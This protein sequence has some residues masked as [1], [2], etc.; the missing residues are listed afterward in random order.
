MK[1]GLVLAGGG[2]RGAYQIGAIKALRELDIDKYIKVVSGTS[3]GALNAM[4]FMNGNL[5][6]SIEVWRNINKE[7]ILPTGENNLNIRS[8]I[9]NFGANNIHFIKKY[10]PRIISG[11]NISRCGLIE[12]MNKID[13]SFVKNSEIICYAACTE[14]TGLKP[15]YFKVNDY[16]EEGIKKIL[17]A[18]SAIPMIYECEEIE[19]VKYLDGGIVD[20]VPI[21]PVYEEGCDIIIIVHLSKISD[22]ERRLF[23]NTHIIEILPTIIEDGL[24]K[25]TLEFN[26]EMSKERMKIGYEDTIEIIKPIMELTRFIDNRGKE[27][28][29]GNLSFKERLKRS[30]KAF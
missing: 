10:I 15:R 16:K 30:I 14:V 1:I 5:D 7:Q 28:R 11:G 3:I 12:I 2:A 19:E 25:G 18:T 13:F 22:I 9:L 17:L 4:L 8:M 6:E 27:Q 21:H 26:E 20:N 29:R 23:P 24:V